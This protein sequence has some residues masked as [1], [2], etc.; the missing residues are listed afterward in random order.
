YHDFKSKVAKGR[1]LS[2]EEV[3]EVAQGRVWTGQKG[4]EIGLVDKLGDL[5]D[6]IGSAATLAG[7]D[8]YKLK[9]YP[10]IKDPFEQFIKEFTGQGAA[11]TEALEQKLQELIPHYERLQT[12]SEING[13]IQAR[14]PYE[15]KVD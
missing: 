15:M 10:K 6:A 2:M 7:I 3:E 5:D 4:L 14:M 13:S 8:S 1:N 12:L 11:Q 9:Y